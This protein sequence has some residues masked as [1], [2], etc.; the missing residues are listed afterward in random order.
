M[1]IVAISACPTGIAHTYMAAEGLE[2]AAKELGYEIKVETQGSGEPENVLTAQDIKEA[3]LVLIAAAKTVDLTR[4]D[5]KRLLEISIEKTVR[6]AKSVLES[7]AKNKSIEVYKAKSQNEMKS[8]KGGL[9]KHLMSGVYTMMPF[10]IA[11]GIIIAISFMF[12]ITASDPTSA[13]YNVIA[14]ALS[15]IGGG[16]AFG[17]MV[18]MLAAG[19]SYSIAGKQGI[20]S[21]A[22]A[23]ML[24]STIGAG[25]LGGLVGGL[26]AG[27]L[28]KF[29]LDYIKLPK[30]VASMKD[31][32][33]V[34]VLSVAITGLLMIFVLG[35]PVKFIMDK[36]TDF[37]NN[38]G[39]ANGVLFGAIAGIMMA[40]D[41]GGPINKTVA[42]FSVGLMASGVNGPIAACMA[43]GMTPPLGLALATV[44]FKNK[45]TKEERA[46][47]KTCWVLGLSYITE[48]AIPFAVSDPGR[49]IPSLM[50]GS[51]VAG[52]ISMAAGCTSLAPHGGIWIAPIPN[53][54]NNLPMY[55]VAIVA[56]M[57][58]TCFCVGF[59]KRK[60]NFA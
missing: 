42:T 48:G 44:V 4:F 60:N 55:I 30:S 56:G 11:G 35:E 22:V 47:G 18:P 38:L 9:Y 7:A 29:L 19:I 20:V 34:P 52:A 46:A 31:L 3:D 1:K 28:T 17:L 24:A 2:K 25:F 58:V 39:T 13:D 51:A 53:V 43:A 5:G 36:M 15:S 41:M 59:L 6:D 12:G 45:F 33:I 40:A 54:I 37:L 10:T 8:S 27:Y 14:G 57:L 21:G 26:F 16:S 32:I 50:A 23:G 49:V